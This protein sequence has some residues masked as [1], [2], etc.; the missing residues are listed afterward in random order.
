M[1]F[2]LPVALLLSLIVSLSVLP[3]RADTLDL[4]FP[5]PQWRKQMA[6]DGLGFDC[7]SEQ[8]GAPAH[9]A[10]FIAPAN[11][12]MASKIRSGALN[13]AW[14]EKLAATYR[15][16]Q[17]DKVT[18][19][20]FAIDTG[21]VPSWSMVYECNCEGATSFISSRTIAREKNTMTFFSLARNA[22]AAQENMNKMI[23]AALGA[24]SR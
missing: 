21:H 2:A 1:R 8:C 4:A 22:E 10:I 18:L 15:R 20:D 12:A 16:T 14:A 6:P 24:N 13:R 23:E 19:L 17:G 7:V 11:P 9:V 3:A 5:A